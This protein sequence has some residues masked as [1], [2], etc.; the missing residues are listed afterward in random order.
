MVKVY[1]TELAYEACDRAMQTLGAPGMT[2]ELPLFH[3]WHRARIMR[4][5][6]GPSA[7]PGHRAS[8]TGSHRVI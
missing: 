6:E 5:Y 1:A 4:I 3:L 8:P 7:S 2:K